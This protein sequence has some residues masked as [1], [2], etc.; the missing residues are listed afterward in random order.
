MP[1]RLLNLQS[2]GLPEGEVWKHPAGTRRLGQIMI[3]PALLLSAKGAGLK[4][5]GTYHIC[6]VS[7]SALAHWLGT[8]V[9]SSHGMA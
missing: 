8:L 7:A 2:P 5:K 3:S 1:D 9:Q 6:R 4:G